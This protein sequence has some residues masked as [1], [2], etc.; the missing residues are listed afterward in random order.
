MIEIKN[1]TKKFDGVFVP[2]LNNVNLKI[3]EGEFCIVLGSNGSGK[4]T[5]FKLISQEYKP[6]AGIVKVHADVAHVTQNTDIATIPEMTLL[7][8]IALSIIKTPKL[9]FYS[10]Y[11][12]L[13]KKQIESLGI[14]IEEYIDQ[15]LRSLS[16]GQK[17]MIAVLMSLVSDSQIL[18]LDEHTSALDPRMQFLLMRYT[19][20]QIRKS[21]LTS[22]MITHKLEDAVQYGDRLIMLSKGRI[23]VD[24]SGK[25]KQKLQIPELLDLFHHFED[26]NLLVGG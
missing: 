5:L 24:L 14:G 7:E 10:C 3:Q 25:E 4:S 21:K 16:G 26:K 15:P 11:R 12:E 20:E 19:S 1:L 18:L 22:L 2:A 17:Q 6:S 8:N 9:K 13:I 23:V